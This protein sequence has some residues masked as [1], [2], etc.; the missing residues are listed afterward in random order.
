MIINTGCRTDIPAYFSEWFFNRIKEGYVYTRNPYY[1]NQVMKYKLTPDVVDCLSFCTKNPGPI[2]P[3]IHELDGFRQFWFVTITPYGKEIEP[4]VPDKEKVIEDFKKLSKSIG[5]QKIG[6]RYDPIFITDKY[7]LKSHI[8]HF[9]K[10]SSN[11]AGYTHDCV[12]SF[13]DL[14]E[15]TKLNF[16]G[17]KAVTREERFTIAKEFV[18]IGKKYDIQ[19]KTCV[20]GQELSKYGVDCS[21]CMTKSVIEKALGVSLKLHQKKSTRGGCNCLL[22]NDIGVYNTCGHGC[23]YCYANY[24]Q[25]TV[26]DNMKLH[27]P[28]SPFLIG[29]NMNGDIV[30]E[31]KQESYIDNQLMLF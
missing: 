30:K 15:K 29:R 27:N 26:I 7:T 8:E 12:I 22:G 1:K 4:N 31:A 18:H 21:G 25:K 17:V 9:E 3:R 11:L 19:I 24:N 13:I 2:L 23:L 16:P 6:W 28:K 5:S 20:E 10:I 14:Y